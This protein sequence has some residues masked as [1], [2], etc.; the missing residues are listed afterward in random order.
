MKRWLSLSL[1]VLF[2]G[3][4]AIVLGGRYVLLPMVPQYKGELETVLTDALGKRVRIGALQ[5][6]WRGL[7]PWAEVSDFAILEADDSVAFSLPAI[8]A[9]LSWTSL[10]ALEPR[11]SSLL[12]EGATLEARRDRQGRFHVAGIEIP[13]GGEGDSPALAWLLRQGD[14]QVKDARVLWTDL[15]RSKAVLEAADVQF[16]LNNLVN[17]HRA[18]LSGRVISGPSDGLTGS[19][20]EPGGARLELQTRFYTPLIAGSAADVSKW[21]G[22]V[23][24][25]VQSA[26]T[27]SLRPW[28]DIPMWL[29]DLSGGGKVWLEFDS[30]RATRLTV[31]PDIA[32][33]SLYNSQTEH[34]FRLR[35]IAG[36]IDWRADHNGNQQ[37]AIKSLVLT[38]PDGTRLAPMNAEL[39]L[40]DH[41]DPSRR[42]GQVRMGRVDLGI[43]AAALRDA[44]LPQ[45]AGELLRQANP[46]GVIL[47]L[48]ARWSGE[49]QSPADIRLKAEF[50]DLGLQSVQLNP[51]VRLPGFAGLTGRLAAQSDGGQWFI[52]SGAGHVDLHDVLQQTRLPF[53]RLTSEGSWKTSTNLDRR[54]LLDWDTLEI[55]RDGMRVSMQGDLVFGRGEMP[56]ANLSGSFNRVPVADVAGYMPLVIG[57]DTLGWLNTALKGGVAHDG[58]WKLKGNLW[59]FPFP[60]RKR[61]EF[62]VNAR[63][64]KG[65][66]LFASDWPAVRDI[67]G[68][69]RFAN[70]AM[71][72]VA[73]SARTRDAVLNNVTLRIPSLDA[74]KTLLLIEGDSQAALAEM[75]RYVNASP[76]SDMLSGLLKGSMATGN[77]RLALGLRIPLDVPEKTEVKG[78]LTFADNDI[79]IT[80]GVPQLSR[81]RGTL[82]FTE[83]GIS[84]KGLSGTALGGPLKVDAATRTDGIMTIR[85]EGNATATALKRYLGVPATLRASGQTRFAANVV[86]KPGAGEPDITVES[87]LQGIALDLPEPFVKRAN[88]VWPLEFRMLP[89]VMRNGELQRDEIR[90]ALASQK[91]ALL[92]GRIERD[93]TKGK[94]DPVR[95]ALAVGEPLAMPEQGIRLSVTLPELDL[96]QWQRTQFSD[97]SPLSEDSIGMAPESGDA[98][99]GLNPDRISVRAN[100]LIIGNKRFNRLTLGAN[101]QKDRWSFDISAD[102]GKGT[103]LWIAPSAAAGNVAGKLQLNFARL[104]LPESTAVEVTGLPPDPTDLFEVPALDITVDDM[105]LG[106]TRLGRLRLLASNE[107]EGS[108][109]Q[110]IL[111]EFQV[112]NPDFT[113]AGK[114]DWRREQLG[115]PRRT[116]IDFRMDV[117]NSGKL[118]DRVGMEKVL[119]GGAGIVSGNLQWKGPPQSF[120]YAT[121]SGNLKL[122]IKDGQFLK[123]EPGVGRLL[124]ILSFQSLPRRL[125]LDFSDIFAAG[126]AFDQIFATAGISNGVLSTRDFK[127]RGT[128]ATVLLDGTVNLVNETQD[129]RAVVLP[130]INAAGGTLMYS[131]MMANPAVGL[132]AFLAQL[133]LKDPLSKAFSYDM[134]VTGTWD[135]PVVE[136]VERGAVQVPQAGNPK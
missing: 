80:R 88:D 61:G 131:V 89:T 10:A 111:R 123:V 46:Q 87:T 120:D 103:A 92:A 13:T 35:D 15:T 99:V 86:V 65:E 3:F 108:V 133:V 5:A 1:M 74:D 78:T 71:T 63:I 44:P 52:R 112:S 126:F 94:S 98:G 11:L 51:D 22:D 45:K 23:Y 81:V 42:S 9:S 72:V 129:L 19:D 20:G 75:V 49:L 121:M 53:T 24:V 84:M 31:D 85:A 100:S 66:V 119:R 83:S 90:I 125:T 70:E 43:V 128:G 134:K 110:W 27:R 77:A 56:D 4:C 68:D 69:I 38:A 62:F 73:K 58:R 117:Q 37:V 64:Q 118:L 18:A 39:K 29:T 25:S 91:G 116:R 124:G 26:V 59:H 97:T 2:F 127:M 55:E 132:G 95:G 109:K 106:K 16:R 8:S 7:E 130:E 28:L 96:D 114:G 14:I 135:D 34:G 41:I 60:D 76:V 47:D 82:D 67:E 136:K 107:G 12:I 105:N 48:D 57:N 101:R 50:N 54:L 33:L 32:L 115:Q 122:D 21:R 113:L 6:R 17:L 30:L 36:R 93:R 40:E 102:E 104:T 79:F